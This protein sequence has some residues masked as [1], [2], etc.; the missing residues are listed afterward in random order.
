MRKESRQDFFTFYLHSTQRRSFDIRRIFTWLRNRRP[1]FST[2]FVLS[3]FFHVF[4]LGY[5]SLSQASSPDSRKRKEGLDIAVMNQAL[6]EKQ[7]EIL[8]FGSP[9]SLLP[10]NMEEDFGELFGGVD[11]DLSLTDEEKLEFYKKLIESLLALKQ[12]KSL[13]DPGA[14]ITLSDL[15]AFLE[16]EGEWELDS[17]KK[18]FPS[19]PD[20]GEWN[21]KFHSLTK[22]RKDT[23][24]YL[25]RFE[26]Y[27]KNRS[28]IARGQVKVETESGIKYIPI[29]YYFRES[30]Y[31]EILAHG[32]SLFYIIRGFPVVAIEE[33]SEDTDTQVKE[34]PEMLPEERFTVVILSY[35]EAF[36][37]IR[38][39]FKTT[40]SS[41]KESK[42]MN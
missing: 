29:E 7:D 10:D 1:S 26:D 14:E 6:M 19:G 2:S 15:L 40:A 27:E 11:F 20:Q 37:T 5:L 9:D 30:P 21:S 33:K 17:G 36:D 34:K 38:H 23:L 16:K 41:M 12:E 3:V 31:E 25:R 28:Q 24:N 32:V 8:S 35:R 42:K 13:V 39:E 18:I 22:K 4:L